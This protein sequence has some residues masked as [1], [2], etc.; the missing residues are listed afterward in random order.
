[1]DERMNI[2]PQYPI[3]SY[4]YGGIHIK[5]KNRGKFNAL[6]KRTGKSTEELTH[7]K[8]PLTRKRA[9]F[10]TEYIRQNGRNL[11][12]ILLRSYRNLRSINQVRKPLTFVQLQIV[13]N[14]VIHKNTS[15]LIYLF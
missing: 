7:S 15:N 10:S 8:N 14:T 1:M 6:K 13:K 5:K 4:K 12:R 3:P 11:I 2:M 9:I